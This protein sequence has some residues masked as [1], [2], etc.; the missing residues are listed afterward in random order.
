MKKMLWTLAILAGSWIY[1]TI[2][3]P[4]IFTCM[5]ENRYDNGE[6]AEIKTVGYFHYGQLTQLT[7]SVWLDEFVSVFQTFGPNL[8][9]I[10]RKQANGAYIIVSVSRGN[11]SWHDPS[12]NLENRVSSDVMAEAERALELGRKKFDEEL[13]RNR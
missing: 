12:G 10:A 4:L 3:C 9:V 7:Y 5:S 1:A 11:R 6:L 8:I 2:V 13:E